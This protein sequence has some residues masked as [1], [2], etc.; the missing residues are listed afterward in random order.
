MTALYVWID[1]RVPRRRATGRPPVLSDAE[2]LTAAVA[3]AL[4]QVVSERRWLRLITKRLPG[5][6]PALPRQPGYN[7][8]LRAAGALLTRVMR[9]LARDTTFWHDDV[10]LADSTPVG[11]GTSRETVHRSDLAGYAQYGYCASHSRWFWGLR[12]H[13]ICTPAGLPGQWILADK[14]YQRREFAH[15]LTDHGLQLLIP[16]GVCVRVAQRLLALTAAIW[17]NDHTGQPVTRSLIA[18]DH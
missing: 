7:K 11:C 16:A 18:Y 8:R 1:D 3:Q 17:H 15:Q 4:L 6:F 2:L 14:G 9:D 12:L 13:L 5:M 10:W